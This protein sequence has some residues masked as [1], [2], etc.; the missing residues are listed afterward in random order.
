MTY[1][2]HMGGKPIPP[3]FDHSLERSVD[4]AEAELDALG[5]AKAHLV[6]NSLGGWLA[7][8]L[9]R[10]GRALSVV[11]IA[12]AGGWKFKSPEQR[13]LLNKFKRTRALLRV[14]GPFASLIARGA[15]GRRIAL[16]DM[17][18]RPERLTPS[19]ATLLIQAPWRCAV[20]EDVL[21]VLPDEPVARLLHPPPCPMRIVWGV[22]DRVLR[23]RG[24]SEQ[25]IESLPG[26]DF[27]RLHGAGHVPMYDD[28][29]RLAN[30]I[31]EVTAQAVA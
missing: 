30:A 11:A 9:A 28:P 21:R 15:L 18:H 25:W 12:P 23:L 20:Y 29:T 26:V 1:P 31:L 27:V 19:E 16:G 6:G 4:L 2:G 3:G 10:R 7:I 8:E 17:M 5:I 14:A 22:E 24:Y 13:R